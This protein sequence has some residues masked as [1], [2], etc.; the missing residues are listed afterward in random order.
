MVLMNRSRI[1]GNF[2][3]RQ[4]H[5]FTSAAVDTAIAYRRKDSML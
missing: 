2:A 3:V 4:S 5:C 1:S